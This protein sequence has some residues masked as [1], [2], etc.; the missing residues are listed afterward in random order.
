[1]RS[2]PGD[3]LVCDTIDLGAPAREYTKYF[4]GKGLPNRVNMR[5]IEYNFLE[6]IDT[7]Q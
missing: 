2:S 6:F 4:I 7:H 3:A 1:M 5:K